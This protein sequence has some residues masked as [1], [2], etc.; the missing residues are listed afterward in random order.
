MK[1]AH[2]LRGCEI[3][4]SCPYGDICNSHYEVGPKSC[5]RTLL[6]HLQRLDK[7]AMICQAKER[8]HPKTRVAIAEETTNDDCA[9][10]LAKVERGDGMVT[11]QCKHWFHFLCSMTWRRQGQGGQTCPMCRGAIVSMEERKFNSGIR[12]LEHEV[13]Y[14]ACSRVE[15]MLSGGVVM[16]E[17]EIP[18]QPL[19]Q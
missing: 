18:G 4:R 12:Q 9:I 2:L 5:M 3:A 7:E 11:I 19:L 8:G 1:K 17:P 6:E 13:G 14:Q 10:C 15:S 16:P